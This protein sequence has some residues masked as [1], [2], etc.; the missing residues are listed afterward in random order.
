MKETKKKDI[1]YT[2]VDSCNIKQL[3]IIFHTL[4]GKDIYYT[5]VNM[6]CYPVNV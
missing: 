5:F 4:E 3:K 6:T 1:Y 2:F